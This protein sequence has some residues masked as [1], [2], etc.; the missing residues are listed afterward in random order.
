M[1]HRFFTLDVFTRT[2]LEGN[3]LAV[4]LGADDIDPARMQAIAREFALSETVFVLKPADPAHRAR[5]RIFTTA[6]ELPFAGHPTVG[7]AVLLGLL[8][9]GGTGPMVIEEQVGDVA[10]IVS[11]DAAA[12]GGQARFTLPRLPSEIGPAPSDAALAALL[13]VPAEAIGCGPHRPS[14]FSAGV[15]FVLVPLRDLAAV[16]AARPR[17]E[18]WTT[19]LPP[20]GAWAAFVYCRETAAPGRAFHA[21]MFMTDI[22]LAEDPATGSAVAAFAGAVVKFDGPADGS[23]ALVVEQGF[24]MGRP[25]LIEL[26]LRIADGALASASIAGGAVVVGEGTLRL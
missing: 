10:C 16:A 4:V 8:G 17:A 12:E 7:S 25:S 20:A 14:V 9:G 15:P 2:R 21:R 5:I 22:G 3:P 26:G 23:H 11:A 24:E 18:L 19:T 13:G 1:S 6:Q